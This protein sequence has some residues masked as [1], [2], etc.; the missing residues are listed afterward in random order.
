MIYKKIQ[1]F[2]ARG[3]EYYLAMRFFLNFKEGYLQDFLQLLP[4]GRYLDIRK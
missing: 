3:I 1:N 4:A 2:F